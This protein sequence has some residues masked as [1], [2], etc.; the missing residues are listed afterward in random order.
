ML[1]GMLVLVFYAMSEAG[2]PKT[3]SWLFLDEGTRSLDSRDSR[4]ANG[5]LPLKV[6]PDS[7]DGRS[8]REWQGDDQGRNDS[9]KPA[10][11]LPLVTSTTTNNRLQPSNFPQQSSSISLP[12]LPDESIDGM[13]DDLPSVV[14]RFWSDQFRRLDRDQQS[15]LFLMLYYLRN[16]QLDWASLTKAEQRQAWI[17]MIGRLQNQKDQFHQA[18]L[19][20]ANFTQE[21]SERK[22]TLVDD[23]FES[24]QFWKLKLEPA[25]KAV[26]ESA[27]GEALDQTVDLRDFPAEGVEQ[28]QRLLDGF[29]FAQ[30]Q[31]RSGLGVGSDKLAWKRIWELAID[32]VNSKSGS[33]PVTHLE[34]SSQPEFYR[35]RQ[36]QINGFVQAARIDPFTVEELQIERMYTLLVK[37]NDSGISPIFVYC[38]QLPDDFPELTENYSTFYFPIQVNGYFFK[39][40]AYTDTAREIQNAPVVLASSVTM[41]SNLAEVD[42]AAPETETFVQIFA[43]ALLGISILAVIG[44]WVLFRFSDRNR[45]RPAADY[46]DAIREN[47]A[48][49]KNNMDIKTELERVQELN[50]P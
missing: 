41:V 50:D 4:Q 17:E 47:L 29:V 21:S 44:A 34:L 32:G 28:I 36:V 26:L 42:E 16:P 30:V 18:L 1:M 2:K 11:T 40:R 38:K 33:M 6:Q 45:Y 14:V 46:P 35:G 7:R 8:Q 3:W 48:E 12:N 20:E 10:L 23:L 19:S 37:P 15:S 9:Q 24:E 22:K 39:I 5:E 27:E 13:P 49:L 25:F 31:D 43:T